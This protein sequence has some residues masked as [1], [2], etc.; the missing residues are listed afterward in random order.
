LC[1]ELARKAKKRVYK[2]MIKSIYSDKIRDMMLQK[3]VK[4]FEDYVDYKDKI[5]GYEALKSN[6]ST[7]SDKDKKISDLIRKLVQR[8]N[9]KR[10]HA[11]KYKVFNYIDEFNLSPDIM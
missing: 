2:D 9:D 4:N 3:M 8:Q 1:A 10:R 6:A 7:E 5:Q 11:F